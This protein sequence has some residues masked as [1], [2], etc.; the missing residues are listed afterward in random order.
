MSVGSVLKVSNTGNLYLFV[1]PDE[2]GGKF[3]NFINIFKE[4]DFSLIDFLLLFF[5]FLFYS[6]LLW[7]CFLSFPYIGLICFIFLSPLVSWIRSL[8]HCFKIFLLFYYKDYK[9]S[10]KYYFSCIFSCKFFCNLLSGTP[11]IYML[12]YLKLSYKLLILCL[13]VFRHFS[14][15]FILDSFY[16]SSKSLNF[17]FFLQ[18]QTFS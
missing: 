4:L 15:S 7:F 3:I 10:S 18:C 5:Q 13:F 16:Q 6:F 8:N 2:S 17:F 9:F 14:L 11:I 1:F 12:D